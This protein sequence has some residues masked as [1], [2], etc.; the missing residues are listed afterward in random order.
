MANPVKSSD[1]FLNDGAVKQ[2]TDELERLIG[3]VNKLKGESVKLEVELKKANIA[4]ATG[5]ETVKQAGQQYNKLEKELEKYNTAI[6][7]HNIKIQAA[8][9]ATRKATN[10][11]SL[12]QS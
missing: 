1:I 9:E 5:K 6:D 12:Q 3:I 11:P 7:E 2:F 4:T 8:R 10:Y